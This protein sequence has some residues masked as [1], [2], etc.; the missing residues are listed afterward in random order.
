VCCE[1]PHTQDHE[2]LCKQS[3]MFKQT[4]II[5]IWNKFLHSKPIMKCFNTFILNLVI[6]VHLWKWPQHVHRMDTNRLPKQALQ[7][8]PNGRRNIR[9]GGTNFILRI[10]EQDN[11]PNPSGTWWWW[12]TF[13]GLESSIGKANRYGLDGPGIESLQGRVYPRPSSPSLGPTQLPVQ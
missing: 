3:A 6:Q 13:V 1:G 8:K 4:Y 10:K 2:L 7:Y 12:S 11:M 5:L 9:D